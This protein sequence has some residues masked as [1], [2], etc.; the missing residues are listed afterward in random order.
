MKAMI[1]LQQ[2]PRKTLLL[3]GM[4]LVS[5][6]VVLSTTACQPTKITAPGT[7]REEFYPVINSNPWTL[8]A[9]YATGATITL[10]AQ[11]L[12]YSPIREISLSQILTRRL[13]A[14]APLTTDTVRVQTVPYSRAF[15]PTKQC[16]TLLLNYVVP[17]DAQLPRATGTG[18]LTV[19]L[20]VQVLN[21]NTL[22]KNRST[23]TTFTV[24]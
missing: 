6:A 10:E 13:N 3:A 18:T 23:L 12:S 21:Q 22:F 17:P 19:R 7:I 16:D 4:L 1:F 8:A 9:N 24:R 2:S 20:M 15:S 5:L 11:F 14:M